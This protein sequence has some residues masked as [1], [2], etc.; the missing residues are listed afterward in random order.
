MT[1]KKGKDKS[2]SNGNGKSFE[3]K[4][5]EVKTQSTQRAWW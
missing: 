1:S 4:V 3:R 5:R 2:K